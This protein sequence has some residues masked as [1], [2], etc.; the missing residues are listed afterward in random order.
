MLSTK[1]LGDACVERDVIIGT[2]L[3]MRM[4]TNW[5]VWKCFPKEVIVV[6]VHTSISVAILCTVNGFTVMHESASGQM[7]GILPPE[8]ANAGISCVSVSFWP[9]I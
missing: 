9:C 5:R 2:L 1:S 6:F 7:K 8:L 4:M 3:L